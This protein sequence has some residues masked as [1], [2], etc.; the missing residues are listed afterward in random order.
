MSISK[1]INNYELLKAV[2]LHEMIHV[3]ELST[4]NY[5]VKESH[6]KDFYKKRKELKEKFKIKI[7]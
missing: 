5:L 3:W 1:S 2:L 4:K 7:L 6:S